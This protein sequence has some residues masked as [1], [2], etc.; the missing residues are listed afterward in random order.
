MSLTRKRLA[1]LLLVLVLCLSGFGPV[2][3]SA[4]SISDPIVPTLEVPEDM[5]QPSVTD[6]VYQTSNFE[7]MAERGEVTLYPGDS[8]SF[9]NTAS[10]T[11]SLSNNGS[12]SRDVVFDYVRYGSDGRVSTKS[13]NTGSNIN[14]TANSTVIVTV[15]GNYP[16]TFTV[17][18]DIIATPSATPAFH[19]VTLYQG[20]S[21]VFTNESAQ[22]VSMES[23]SSSSQDRRY[24][25]AEYSPDGVLDKSDFNSVGSPS[26]KSG[27]EIIITGA[28]VNPVTVAFPYD[29]FNGRYSGEPAYSRVTLGQGDSYRF[30]NVSTKSDTLESDGKTSDRF[31]YVVYLP[32]GTEYSRGTNTSN[33][34]TVAAGRTAVI[35]MVTP[36]PVT[37]GVPY[38]TFLVQPA[39]GAAISR[40]TIEPGESYIFRNNGSL[41][42]PIRN[43]A[44]SVGG[45]FDYV[46]YRQD[47][48]LYGNG[49]NKK[50]NPSIP[51]LGYAVVSNVGST[52]IIFD[53][54]DDFSVERTAEPAFERVTL[55]RGESYEF[56]NVSGSVETLDSDAT[57]SSGGR[58]DYV[59]YYEDGTERSRRQSTTINPRVNPNNKVVVTV[60]SDVPVTF[61]AIYTVF[62]GGGRP[63]EA[64]S[65]ITINPGESYI[66][67]N[68]GSRNN[69]IRNNAR[70]VNGIFDYVM[71]K[72][73]D[74]LSSDGFN[75]TSNPQ[76]P[77]Q[78]YAIVTVAGSASITFDYTDDFS[79]APSAEPAYLRVTLSRGESFAFTNISS[80]SENLDSTASISGNRKYD[81]VIYDQTGA[82]RTRRTGA[83]F[84][85]NIQPGH[86]VV[87]TTASDEPISYGGIYRVFRGEHDPG[88]AKERFT[89]APGDSYVVYNYG[90]SVELLHNARQ[91]GAVMDYAIY[92]VYGLIV[93][94][95]FN[96]SSR[97]E[98]PSQAYVVISNPSSVPIQYEYTE[99]DLYVDVS[100]EPAFHRYVVN[101]GN[102][103]QLTNIS[104]YPKAIVSL[105]NGGTSSFNYVLYD[106]YGVEID[107]KIGTTTEPVVAPGQRVIVT[108]HSDSSILFGGVY[109]YFLAEPTSWPG[110]ERISVGPR[111]SV[112]FTNNGLTSERVKSD[113]ASGERFYDYAI[114]SSG[115]R[116]V[117]AQMDSASQVIE[118]PAGGE[119]VV[120]VTSA[121]AV[122][123]EYSDPVTVIASDEQALI[124]Q[125][126][127]SGL[128]GE[129]SNTCPYETVL[130]SNA[131]LILGRYYDYKLLDA[132]GNTLR[133]GREIDVEQNIPLRGKIQVTVSSI[134]PVTFAG[135]S[136]NIIYADMTDKFIDLMERRAEGVLMEQDTELYYRFQPSA[137][138]RYR[139]AVRETKDFEKEPQIAL[140]SDAGMT[141]ELAATANQERQHGWDYT[142]LEWE[143]EAGKTYYLKLTEND[144]EAFEGTIIAALMQIAAENKYYY[145]SNNRLSRV[146]LIT[147]DEILYEYDNN[148]NV[149][150]RRKKVFPF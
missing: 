96:T 108:T 143:L 133:E 105:A 104:P 37:F 66:F 77:A 137:S 63:N 61:G 60:V 80:R 14:I 9:Y 93:S 88:E 30:T 15:N 87:V 100:R 94:D 84:D 127:T 65:Q 149:I 13:M 19:R 48:S 130:M 62:E 42:N 110:G 17:L 75:R 112:I 8:Y 129:F 73:D 90:Q 33:K 31:D 121:S 6:A 70:Q 71:Y 123:F 12:S 150:Q 5:I 128:Q 79:V 11:K 118:I 124:R 131:S 55:Y 76:V 32:D 53:Y 24:D 145:S 54:T 52:S 126:L 64:I 20:D 85:P 132:A 46:V 86:T 41:T 99:G 25:Y 135:P 38:R 111:E 89:I 4:Q 83:T 113:A 103:Y 98:L 91:V 109:Q 34:P 50:S 28:S 97:L 138:G 72:A 68:H 115:V 35:T 78:G 148:G 120:T 119:A 16:V 58:Y 45:V 114:Y 134:Q 82:E 10:T 2:T 49:F 125:E 140:Y 102:S 40:I 27:N 69:P 67:H 59:I 107:W 18:P 92:N 39:D 26:V 122:S 117:G 74:S 136:R 116:T 81:Y 147:G 23:D 51:A 144:G 106:L 7:I 1:L 3:S 44:S 141:D 139:F 43:D 142:V 47:S 21:Y 22:S 57:T 146:V 36:N 101:P 95:E 56:T 29:V